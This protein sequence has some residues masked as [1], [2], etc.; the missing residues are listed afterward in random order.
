MQP[1]NAVAFERCL[2]YTEDSSYLLLLWWQ[3]VE[4]VVKIIFIL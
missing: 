4:L 3:V 1:E 2:Q